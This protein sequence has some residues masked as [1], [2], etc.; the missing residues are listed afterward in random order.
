MENNYDIFKYLKPNE[1]TKISHLRG[2]DLEELVTLINNYYLEYRDILNISKK[3][4]IGSEIE[5]F[6]AV[7]DARR[8]HR[9]GA[10]I[11]L[12]IH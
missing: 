12:L 8:Q 10:R 6:D 7:A 9:L 2:Y 4:S 1:N 5:Y 3:A 11:A